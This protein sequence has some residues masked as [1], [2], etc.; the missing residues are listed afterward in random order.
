MKEA[1]HPRNSEI[2]ALVN[3]ARSSAR[4]VALFAAQQALERHP[5]DDDAVKE[6]LAAL[7]RDDDVAATDARSALGDLVQS[8]DAVYLNLS[9]KRGRADRA[10]LDAFSRARAANALLS[11]LQVDACRAA[12]DAIY[13]A[14]A[15]F[16][17]GE[18][19]QFLETVKNQLRSA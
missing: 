9:E 1:L 13:E 7:R 3:G 16:E 6:A 12:L 8:L 19:E 10:T 4:R 15:S 14:H 11:A 18:A 5:I 2:V 17:E